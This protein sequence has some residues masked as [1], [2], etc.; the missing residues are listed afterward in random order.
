MVKAYEKVLDAHRHEAK[1]DSSPPQFRTVK[2]DLAILGLD[3]R[4]EAVDDVFKLRNILTH[5]RGELRT[6]QEREQYTDDRFM[7]YLAHLS[8]EKVGSCLD[9]LGSAVD[10]LDPVLWAYSWGRL[11]APPLLAQ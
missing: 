9:A 8:E 6:R 7:G 4:P 10:E 1:R 3:A 5:Q 11:V 2:K